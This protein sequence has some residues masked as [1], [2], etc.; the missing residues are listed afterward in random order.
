MAA[1]PYGTQHGHPLQHW[2]ANTRTDACYAQ[3]PKA[4]GS[5]GRPALLS[6]R[7]PLPTANFHLRHQS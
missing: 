4:S 5:I 2:N 6:L 3:S 1:M 7:K